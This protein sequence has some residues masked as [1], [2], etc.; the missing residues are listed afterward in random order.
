MG[1]GPSDVPGRV[2]Q[3]MAAPCIGHL[4]PAFLSIMDETQGLLRYLFQTE[5]ALTI[6]VSGT[7]SAGMETCFVN[8]IEPGDEVVVCVNGVF[9]TRMCDIVTRVGGRLIRVDAQWGETIDPDA[10][11]HAV[12]GKDPKLLAVVHAET[13]TGV[14]QPLEELSR[15][16]KEAGALFLVDMVTSLAGLDVAL[17]RMGIDAAYSGTQ[18]CISCPPGLSPISFSPAA[19]EVLNNRKTP[20]ISWY[21]DMSM[22]SNYWGGERKYHHTAPINMVYGLREA[23][24]IIAEEGLEA[25]FAR[26]SVNHRALVAGLEAMGLSMLVAEGER[27]PMLN[28]VRIPEGADDLKVRR[29]LLGDFGVEIGGGLGDLAGKIWRV[30]LMGH[31]SRR[32]NVFLFLSAL[33]TILKG[34]GVKVQPGALEAASSEYQSGD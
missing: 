1:P 32:K 17:D 19:L 34:Q 15:I 25:R 8:L 12:K 6:P 18:K 30:G 31:S 21:L 5:N 27:L 10:V 28:A 20:V 13:S 3:A 11:S 4:D 24:R 14:L 16:A 9:G 33:E 2:L 29:A 26:H 7:G 23:L 22:V